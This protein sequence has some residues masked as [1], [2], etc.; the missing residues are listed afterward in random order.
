[1]PEKHESEPKRS[2]MMLKEDTGSPEWRRRQ[3]INRE[4][5]RGKSVNPYTQKEKQE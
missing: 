5:L 4:L 1:M 2:T 3:A